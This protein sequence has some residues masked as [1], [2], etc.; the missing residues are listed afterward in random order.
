MYDTLQAEP[1]FQEIT[2]LIRVGFEKK[3][4]LVFRNDLGSIY[5]QDILISFLQAVLGRYLRSVSGP[6]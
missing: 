6:F 5:F 4:I 1:R 3:Q 2:Q